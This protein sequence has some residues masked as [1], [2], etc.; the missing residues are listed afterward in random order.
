MLNLNIYGEGCYFKQHKDTHIEWARR[1]PSLI[2]LPGRLTLTHKTARLPP[3][4]R[5]RH[6]AATQQFFN[7]NAAPPAGLLPHLALLVVQ[8]LDK[9]QQQVC[10]SLATWTTR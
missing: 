1:S 8:R 2:I 9:Q 6:H 10:A 7:F 4:P 3:R 5:R